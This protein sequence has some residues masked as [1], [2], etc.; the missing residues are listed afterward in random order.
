MLGLH[1]GLQADGHEI[2]DQDMKDYRFETVPLRAVPFS[3]RV[4]LEYCFASRRSCGHPSLWDRS[5][6][7]LTRS[8]Q[9]MSTH[10]GQLGPMETGKVGR[11]HGVL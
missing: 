5:C 6:S 11:A 1:C 8:C 2:Y 7:A 3:L 10:V 4:C 9:G